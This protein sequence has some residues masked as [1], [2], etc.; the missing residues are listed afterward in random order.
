MTN[1]EN[2]NNFDKHYFEQNSNF[3]KNYNLITININTKIENH[4]R[5]ITEKSY[6]VV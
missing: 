3:D 2:F 5:Q 6:F 1:I 4:E